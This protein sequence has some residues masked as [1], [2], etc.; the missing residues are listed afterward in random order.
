MATVETPRNFNELVRMYGA[1]RVEREVAELKD[2]GLILEL[3][4]AATQSGNREVAE[5]ANSFLNTIRNGSK[6][7]VSEFIER[8]GDY[9][10]LQI[11]GQPEQQHL[12]E[13]VEVPETETVNTGDRLEKIVKIC[14][15]HPA[16]M[17]LFTDENKWEERTV[18]GKKNLYLKR[19][20]LAKYFAPNEG[21]FTEKAQSLKMVKMAEKWSAEHFGQP[22]GTRDGI[23]ILIS[24]PEVESFLIW[25]DENPNVL[26]SYDIVKKNPLNQQL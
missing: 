11:S 6:D 7:P 3:A 14:D 2:Q 10:S 23:S 15:K 12:P 8:H 5:A 16:I 22:L 4:I 19:S 21:E 1:R 24:K 13:A 9:M 25:I 18:N 26:A 20:D 17:D